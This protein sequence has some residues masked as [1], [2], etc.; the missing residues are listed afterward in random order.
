MIK[1]TK[2]FTKL[3]RIALR[4][5]CVV[6]VPA[7]AQASADAAGTPSSAAPTAAIA[8]A[9]Q[10][11]SDENL[12]GDIVVTA[13]KRSQNTQKI[14]LSISAFGGDQLETLGVKDVKD[15]AALVPGFTVAKSFRGPPIYTLRGVGF[16]TPNMSTSSPV[17]IYLDEVAYPYPIMT[18]G[19]SFDLERVEVLKGPQ[20]TLYGRNTTGG[21]VNSIARKPSQTTEGYLK[22]SYGSYQSY[23]LEGALGGGITDTLS[24]RGAFEIDRSDKGWQVSVTRGDRLG[25]V[26]KAAARLAVA[27]DPSDSAKFLLTGN[28]WKDQS[29]TQAAQAIYVYPKGLVTAGVPAAAWSTVGP[30][31]GI[32]V[33]VF[34]QAYNPTK[35]SQANWVES[36]IPWGGTV[37]GKNFTPAPVNQNRKDNELRSIALRGDIKITDGIKLTSLTSYADFKRNEGVDAAGW[38]IENAIFKELGSIKSFSQELRLTGESANFSWIAGLFYARDKIKETDK[39]WGATIST[40]GPLR[41][42]GS[43]AAAAAG[44]T[45]AQQ[46]DI[47]WGFRD[48]QNQNDQTVTSKAIFG[49]GEYRLGDL[50]LTA[51]IRYNKDDAKF[52]GCSRDQGDNSIAA[53]WNGFFN[54]YAH[55]PANV[56]PG[57]CV[58]YLADLAPSLVP[59]GPAFP[60]QGFVKKELKQDNLSG[61]LAL[62]WQ[63]SPS[64]LAYGYVARGFKSGAFPN[65]DAN[66]AIQ[67]NPAK[68]EEVIA[69][70]T[71]IK[72][73]PF[74]GVT[75]NVAGFYYDYKNKQVFGYV[76]DIIFTT[77][78]R[79]VNIPKSHLYGAEIEASVQLLEGLS[80][81]FTASYLKTKIDE[82]DGYDDFGVARNFKGASFTFTPKVQLNGVLSYGRDISDNFT[83]R[84][85][86]SARYS[87]K[88]QADL[89]GD[90]RFH[91][92]AYTLVDTNLL[93]ATKDDKYEV[94]FFVKNLTNKYYWNSAQLNQDSL[95]RYAG[96]PRT[97][98]MSFKSRF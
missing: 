6:S 26:D 80:T 3:Y 16:N 78:N 76:P 90:P 15:I 84:I 69:Y 33:Q 43:A 47:R 31:L 27:W 23:G 28:W 14:G 45:L 22:A 35:A 42:L 44:A 54:Y 32:P 29:D 19:L 57:G 59:G 46:E 56:A 64:L 37:G 87:G 88:Q 98:G 73:K 83:A 95:V 34:G 41:V 13:Q 97:W 62:N 8:P 9:V 71:G 39:S 20:G 75:L 40:L 24:V 2:N 18:E 85:T 77:L 12:F 63:A 91:I 74:A 96:M 52:S 68:Q 81:H 55:I 70:E 67:Y 89:V 79:I 21:L 50:A 93:L 36:Q 82:Y 60:G 49:Q 65:I 7:F 53:T 5:S 94:E 86:A 66:V 58:T 10:Q 30:T 1:D 11:G 38:D 17:G 61:K 25:K 4:T 92:A 48:W 51:G 72:S